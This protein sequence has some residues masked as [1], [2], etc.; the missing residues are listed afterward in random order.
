M[1]K[2]RDL[3]LF[4]PRFHHTTSIYSYT[5]T[6]GEKKK[7]AGILKQERKERTEKNETRKNGME[8]GK[9]RKRE[10][11]KERK[12]TPMLACRWGV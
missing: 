4:P 6:V 10:R 9:S 2:W 7:N 12:K 8:G 11:K 3:F 5:T 1:I